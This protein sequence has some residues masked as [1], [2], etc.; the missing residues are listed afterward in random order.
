MTSNEIKELNDHPID[1]C[2]NCAKVACKTSKQKMFAWI[3]CFLM[4]SDNAHYYFT[5]TIAEDILEKEN[6]QFGL[7]LRFVLD[8]NEAIAKELHKKKNW[9]FLTE[10]IYNHIMNCDVQITKERCKA[11]L[12]PK[13]KIDG[14]VVRVEY[15]C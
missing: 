1:W 8:E 5:H 14:E 13:I 7:N 10:L 6:L 9:N 12:K 3:V 2:Y 11:L 4:K 15:K